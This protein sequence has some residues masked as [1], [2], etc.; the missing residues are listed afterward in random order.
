MDTSRV[1]DAV[2]AQVRATHKL[3]FEHELDVL[4]GRFVGRVVARFH[5]RVGPGGDVEGLGYGFQ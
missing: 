4:G 5:R 3:I 1:L 2:I